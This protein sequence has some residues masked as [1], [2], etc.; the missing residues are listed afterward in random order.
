VPPRRGSTF[1]ARR[2]ARASRRHERNTISSILHDEFQTLLDTE[3]ELDLADES[4]DVHERS[5]ETES[6]DSG[7]SLQL[8]LNKIGRHPLLTAAEEVALAKRVERGDLAAKEQMINSNLR[9][10]VSIAKR[11]RG[12]GVPFLDLIQDGV[13]GLNRAVEKF[14]WRKGFKFS[15]YATWWIRQAISRGIANTA[16]TIRLPVHARDRLTRLRTAQMVLEAQL[17][18]KPTRAELAAELD[19]PVEVVAEILDRPGDPR[20]LSESMGE[21]GT[22]ELA[23]LVADRSATSPVEAAAIALLPREVA[24]LL[25]RLAPRERQ[26]LTL[27]FGLDR[28]DPRTLEEV[29]LHFQLTRERIRQIEARAMSKLRHPVFDTHAHELLA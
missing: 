1:A 12:H 9:L 7:D 2:A 14:D 8:F 5:A 17:M 11:Y 16:S 26:I 10:V 20:S 18:R 22:T 6:P 3:D 19:L 29:G 27:R 13:I 4:R 23:D 21:D 28:G 24:K 25:A 15:T